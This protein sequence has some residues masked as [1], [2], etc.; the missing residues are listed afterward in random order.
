MVL[1]TSLSTFSGIYTTR[2]PFTSTFT[3]HSQLSFSNPKI[4]R[5]RPIHWNLF[6]E[7]KTV[8]V[9]KERVFFHMTLNVSTRLNHYFLL[10]GTFEDR[11]P[12]SSY[13]PS[14]KGGSID[15]APDLHLKPKDR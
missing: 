15:V 7:V 11:I 14:G 10:L 9:K 4:Q 12:S 8:G 5:L 13:I 3:I 2:V 6:N 1:F